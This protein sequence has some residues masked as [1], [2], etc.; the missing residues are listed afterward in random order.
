M[1]NHFFFGQIVGILLVSFV[2]TFLFA[3]C[4]GGFY[5]YAKEDNSLFF[6]LRNEKGQKVLVKEAGE[7]EIADDVRIEIPAEEFESEKAQKLVIE[8]V[9][10][11]GTIRRR[12][13]KIIRTIP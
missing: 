13:M 9:G 4:L 6:Y 12:T 10:D 2:L 7:L 5:S 8:V 11:E 3:R 1:K